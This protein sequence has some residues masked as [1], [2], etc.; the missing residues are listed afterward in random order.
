MYARKHTVSGWGLDIAQSDQFGFS[1]THTFMC[2]MKTNTRKAT[3]STAEAELTGTCR[4]GAKPV[5][6][7]TPST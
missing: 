1:L 3:A 7:C 4:T 2:S 6:T 5:T